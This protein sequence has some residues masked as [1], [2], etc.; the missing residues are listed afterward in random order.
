M[1]KREMLKQIEKLPEKIAREMANGQ[2]WG[3]RPVLSAVLLTILKAL[4]AE[5]LTLDD[6]IKG[7]QAEQRLKAIVTYLLPRLPPD[8]FAQM[9]REMGIDLTPARRSRRGSLL[10]RVTL[11]LPADRLVRATF[12]A[13]LPGAIAPIKEGDDPLKLA[14]IS[15][16][17]K[18][19]G[20]YFYET[21]HGSRL[22]RAPRVSHMGEAS[23]AIGFVRDPGEQ[24][25]R[26]VREQGALC[27]KVQFALWA[28]SA[29]EADKEGWVTVPY[30]GLLDDLGYKRKKRAHKPTNKIALNRVLD[31]LGE[32]RVAGV[33]EVAG[34]TGR[35]RGRLWDIGLEADTPDLKQGWLPSSIR[36]KP[37]E[38][39]TGFPQWRELNQQIAKVSAGIL[40]LSNEVQDRPA[41]YIACNLATL[42]RMNGYRSKQLRGAEL[43][44]MAGL[45]EPKPG[46]MGES[47][48]RALDRLAEVGV[49][50]SWAYVTPGDP[51]EDPD[52][53]DN[54]VTLAGLADDGLAPD[55]RAR[56]VRIEWPDA[57]QATR[58]A[59]A[60]KK[61]RRLEAAQPAKAKRLKRAKTTRE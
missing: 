11:P 29:D 6:E 48:E 38:W 61:Q 20:A 7:E 56:R 4:Q 18:W 2:L 26:T 41:L 49:I 23:V 22:D 27:G 10:D 15:G 12:E 53:L 54:L 36:F 39:F 17:E 58:V 3:E 40:K 46:R 14:T 35:L 9:A 57:L 32:L 24:I 44:R 59:L 21:E 1:N 33:V 19:F 52:D 42:A 28:H 50:K 30:N 13:L 37:G 25:A 60:D 55:F 8:K 31:A 45:R 34:K 47:V 5:G 16:G 51:V 43:A